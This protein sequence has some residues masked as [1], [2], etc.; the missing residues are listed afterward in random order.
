MK[1]FLPLLLSIVCLSAAGQKKPNIVLLFADDAGYA[2]FG[3]HGSTEMKTPNLDRLAKQSVRATQ[4]YVSDPTCGPSRAGLLTGKYQQRFGYEENNVPGF[5]SP[6]SAADGLEMGLPLEEKTIADYLKKVGYTSAIFG[7]WHQ[8]GAD[9]FHPLKRGFDTFAGFRGGARSFFAYPKPPA[10][11]QNKFE[12]GFN[13]FQEPQKYLTDLLADEAVKFISENKEKPFFAYVAFNAVHTPMEAT[14]EDL[15]Q[16]PNLKGDRKV[17]AA[18]M[19][20]MDRACGKILDHLDKEGLTENTIVIFTNDN[21]G[22]IEHNA[23]I[24]APLAGAKASHLEGGIRVPFLIKWPGHLTANT[25]YDLPI[26]TLDFLPTFYAVGGGNSKELTDLDGVDIMPFLSGKEEARPHEIMYWKKDARC[27]VREGDWKFIR[28]PDR[29]AELFRIDKDRSE[30]VNLATQYPDRI[31]EMY[32]MAF[33]WEV[34]LE[35]PRWML[36]KKYEQLDIELMDR[37]RHP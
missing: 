22:P 1:K 33:D 15:A 14:E 5:M 21:G 35:R 8:G 18:M 19:L 4:A 2:D 37:Y 25:T 6:V 32:K 10:D 9:R 16:F 29:P 36:Q 23:S 28:Y 31:K 7:K 20:A 17:A 12:Y 30:Q 3:F 27:V 11:P 26:S 13:N 34:T 24:N